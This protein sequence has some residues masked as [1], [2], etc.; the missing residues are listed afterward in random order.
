MSTAA[1]L[2]I[3]WVERG[4]IPDMVIRRAIRR[5]CGHRLRELYAGDCKAAAQLT[6]AFVRAMDAAET[7]PLPQ[8]AN[9]QHYEVPAE[10]FGLVLGAQRKYSCAWW[11]EGTTDLAPAETAALAVTCEHAGL[12]DGQ[13]VLELGCGWGS[14]TLWVAERY[15]A[16]RITG[17]SNSHSQRAW[18]LGEAE[19]RGLGKVQI[20]TADM[21]VFDIGRRFDRVVSVEMFEHMRNWR[22]L[23]ARVHRWL[24]PGGRFFLHIFCHRSTPYAFIDAGPSDWMSRHFFS[25]GMMPSDE[26]PLRFQEHL[27]FLQHWRWDGTHYEKTANAW[28]ENLDARREQALTVLAATYGDAAAVR[29]LQRWRMFFMACAELFSYR[30]GQ[31]WWVSHYLFERPA[32]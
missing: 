6:E 14:L 4:Y 27:R 29:W 15:P 32:D 3:D 19:R 18:V 8:L 22:S 5:L 24:R 2:A 17:I 25:G 11:P 23:F 10:F 26:L 30:N 9:E 31:E 21:N 16:S 7:A 28:L 13:D 20:L 1:R 12:A